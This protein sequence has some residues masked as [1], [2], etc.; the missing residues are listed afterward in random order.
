M[1]NCLLAFDQIFCWDYTRSIHQLLKW[2][3]EYFWFIMLP[4]E[5]H[6]VIEFVVIQM[7][8]RR[9]QWK[10]SQSEVRRE[11]RW[12]SWRRS[13]W[14]LYL[15]RDIM[16]L[17]LYRSKYICTG[18]NATHIYTFIHVCRFRSVTITRYANYFQ[19]SPFGDNILSCSC[20]I[21]FLLDRI[22]RCT[23]MGRAPG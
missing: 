19:L 13:L 11:W 20:Y 22:I 15:S 7:S 5:P 8:W 12:R 6:D 21:Y 18:S 4:I 23:M 10:I 17:S 9:S 1:A 3:L 2:T 16:T 14:S